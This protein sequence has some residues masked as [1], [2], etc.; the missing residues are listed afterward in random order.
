MKILSNTE[1]GGRVVE[2]S[3]DEFRELYALAKSCDASI[4]DIQGA[5][6][7]LHTRNEDNV[8]YEINDFDFSEPLANVRV[9][10]EMQFNINKIRNLIDGIEKS[11]K[12]KSS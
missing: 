9:F 3:R 7:G 6:W 4:N 1:N 10:Y 12:R 11:L 2:L 5:F 8:F